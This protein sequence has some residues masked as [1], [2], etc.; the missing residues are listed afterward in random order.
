MKTFDP[1][2]SALAEEWLDCESLRWIDPDRADDLAATI[3]QAIED[4]I[5]NEETNQEYP[6]PRT[7]EDWKT[8]AE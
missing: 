2:C 7:A 6:D 4:W 5:G 1:K 3:Q 8:H